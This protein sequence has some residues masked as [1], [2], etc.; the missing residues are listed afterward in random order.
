MNWREPA[1]GEPEARDRTWQVVREAFQERLP[2]PHKTDW[3]PLAAAAVGVA[4]LA[5]AFTPPG[6]AVLGSI[7]DAVQGEQ[8]A[9]PALSSLPTPR[10]RLLVNSAQGAWVVQSDGS[11]RLLRGYTDSS[12]SP[13]GLYVAG[14]HGNE[15]RAIEP[16]GTRH[17]SIGR[18]GALRAPRWSYDGFRVA[19]FSG[20]RLRIVNGDGTGDR[21]LTR[22]ARS[23]V[24]AWQPR[25]HSLAYVSRRGDI[26]IVDVD[27]PRRSAV[28]R[29]RIAPRQLHWTPDGRRLVAVGPHVVSVFGQ[30]GGQLR[31]LDRGRAFLSSASVSPDGKSVAFVESEAGRSSLQLTGVAAGPTRELFRGAGSFANAIWAPDGRWLLLDW[32]SAD[33]WLFIRSIAVKEIIAVSNIRANF[34]AQPS[35]VGWCC[36]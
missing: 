34:G 8:N 35:L 18:L 28:I 6:H 9:K 2:A 24:T 17:W 7:R 27:R 13:H 36:P 4:A 10:T 26:Q 12:W 22:E 29:T 15:L 1:P 16:N 33:Q 32:R 11:K 14:V 19:Y 3:R 31:R 23:G 30:R 5:A 21:L 20:Q 25:T